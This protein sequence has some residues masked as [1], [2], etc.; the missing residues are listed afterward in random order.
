MVI[1]V[2]SG[3]IKVMSKLGLKKVSVALS[4][5]D[6][7]PEAVTVVPAS[8]FTVLPVS[9]PFTKIRSPTL[10]AGGASSVVIVA[11]PTTAAAAAVVCLGA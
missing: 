3:A 2:P 7:V 6:K 11:E 4:E 9:T 10:A 1:S 5:I 8:A